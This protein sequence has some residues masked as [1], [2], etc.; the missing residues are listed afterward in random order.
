[1][2]N[3]KLTVAYDGTDYHGFQE[4]RGSGVATIQDRLE[5]A[6]SKL[7]KRPVQ[8]IGAGRTDSGVHAKGQVVNFRCDSWPVPL[9]KLPL[10]LNALLP[11]DIV[12]TKAEEVSI[13]FH[14]RFSAIGKTYIYTI[15]NHRLPDPF[16]R[17]FALHEPRPLDH[18]AMDR[19]A[20]Y[21]EG[22]HDFKSFQAQGTPVITT[23]RKITE[24]KVERERDKVYIILTAN[25]FLYNMV[26]IIAGTL[27]QVGLGKISPEDLVNILNSKDRTQA[28]PTVPPQG[29]RM[30]KVYY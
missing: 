14:A 8:V 2:R 9:E 4:Q 22:E 28:G 25:G 16:S 5:K 29:L 11:G 18:R 21:L 3:I 6:L 13:D 20:K 15:H 26:R 19:A 10:A 17:R 12:V 30:E 23:V 1:M 24:A 7:A 27:I